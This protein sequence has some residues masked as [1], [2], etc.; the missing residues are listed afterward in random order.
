[1][2]TK[3]RTTRAKKPAEQAALRTFIIIDWTRFRRDLRATM[4]KLGDEINTLPP[5]IGVWDVK[6]MLDDKYAPSVPNYLALCQYM[7]RSPN[8]YVVKWHGT[9]QEAMIWNL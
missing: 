7:K 4:K 6:R 2:A 1:M 8:G 5:Y 3:K 9:A